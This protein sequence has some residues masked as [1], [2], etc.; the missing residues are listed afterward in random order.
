MIHIAFFFYLSLEQNITLNISV[1]LS[2]SQR[3]KYEGEVCFEELAQWQ[4]CFLGPQATS[5]V[6][7]PSLGDQQET[8]TTASQL[9]LGFHLLGPGAECEAAFRPFL[10]LYLFGS[11]DSYNKLNQVTRADCVKLTMDVCNREFNL[12]RNVM[13]LPNCD[14]FEDQEIQCVDNVTGSGSGENYLSC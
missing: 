7:L 11:C 4:R 8:E 2:C 9:L 13:E 10:C 5:D 3:V 6:Y 14:M 1:S 12:A